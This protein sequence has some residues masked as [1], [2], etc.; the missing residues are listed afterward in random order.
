M[1]AKNPV[2]NE[3]I[4]EFD[5]LFNDK[6]DA[7]VSAK[8]SY[9]PSKRKRDLLDSLSTSS[10]KDSLVMSQTIL[11]MDESEKETSAIFRKLL[12]E[13]ESELLTSP[14]SGKYYIRAH[15]K[16][17]LLVLGNNQISIVNHVYGYNVPLSHKSEKML[18]ETFIE[19]VEKRRNQMEDEY[20]NNVQ[21]SL[22]SI[23]KKL[24][25]KQK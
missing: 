13:P 10:S 24:N 19:E 25:E 8:P 23:I 16:S 2:F 22:K 21:H 6:K 17:M 12:K 1:I 18:T 9:V 20:K 4:A 15:D 11:K 14:L 3:K 7:A 5:N